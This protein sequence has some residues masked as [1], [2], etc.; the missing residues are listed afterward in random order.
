MGLEIGGNN[1]ERSLNLGGGLGGGLN[2]QPGLGG[3]PQGAPASAP[4]TLTKGERVTLMKE[5]D[6]TLDELLV[7]LGWDINAD[8]YGPKFDLDVSALVLDENGR[9]EVGYFVCFDKNH[10]ITQDGA[11]KHNGDNLTGEGDGYDET[12]DIIVSKLAPTKKK[13]LILAH[14]YDARNRRQNFGQVSNA[15][16]ALENRKTGQKL[17]RFD[18]TEDYSNYIGLEVAEIYKHNGEVKFNALGR[19]LNEE[20]AETFRRYGLPV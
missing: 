16:I 17:L 10:R 12:L 20:F 9:C 6:M 15:F 4:L 11:V 5:G 19:G 18:L 8:P 1:Q 2:L 14:I 3:V 13:I 7:G